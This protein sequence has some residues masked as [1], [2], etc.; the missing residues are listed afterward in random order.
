MSEGEG[1]CVKGRDVCGACVCVCVRECV[2][3]LV[4]NV[5]SFLVSPLPPSFDRTLPTNLVPS[6]LSFNLASLTYTSP[7]LLLL[8]FF[9]TSSPLT[10]PSSPLISPLLTFSLFFSP[11][12]S[13]Y[14][15]FPYRFSPLVLLSHHPSL[16]TI[17]E[18]VFSL[19]KTL[20][21]L[22]RSLDHTCTYV[23]YI[24]I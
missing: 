14:L 12:S 19:L 9:L 11:P 10:P 8:L 16:L 1:V 21:A 13:P 6:S 4:K 18:K 24:T 17:Q 23:Q 15:S 3:F 20:L 22:S 2:K 7:F 5:I